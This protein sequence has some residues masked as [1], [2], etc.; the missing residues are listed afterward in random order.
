MNPS[1]RMLLTILL[2]LAGWS[3]ARAAESILSYQSDIE[4]A[5]DASMRV[6]ETITVRAEGDRIK[7]GIYRDFP[8]T[9]RDPLGQR[10]VTGFDIIGA[11]RDGQPEPWHSETLANGVRMYL[12]DGN[13]ILPPG[14][15][16]YQIEY[17]TTR[18]LGFFEDHDELYWNVTGNG[19]EFPIERASARVRLPQSVPVEQ[20]IASGYTGPTGSTQ[21]Q[22]VSTTVAGGADYRTTVPLD[23]E[24]GLSIVLQFPKGVVDEPDTQQKLLWL[25]ADNRQLLI[26]ALGLLLLWIYYVVMWRRHGRDPARGIVMP[27]YEPP[28]GY[29]PASLRYIRRMGYDQSCFAAA[30]IGLAAKGAISI[31]DNDGVITL[32]RSKDQPELAAGEAALLDKLLGSGRSIELKSSASTA[33]R[34]ASAR[35]AHEAALAADYEKKYFLTHRR[36]LI[37][38]VIFSIVCLLVAVIAMPGDAKYA[39]LFL[40]VFLSLWSIGTYAMVTAAFSAWRNARGFLAHLQAVPPTLISM[41]FLAGTVVGLVVLVSQAGYGLMAVFLAVI[42]TNIAFYHWMKEPTQDGAKLIDRIDGFR[43]YLGVAEKQELDAR[44]R[45]EDKPEQFSTFLPY[46]FALD[47]EQAWAR[48]FSDALPDDQL[49]KAQPDW[50]RTTGSTV[51]AVGCPIPVGL[52]FLQLIIGQGVRESPCPGLFDVEREGVG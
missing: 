49:K 3:G 9:Y 31:K 33:R 23:S 34:M 25:L 15:Y 22:L 1:Y 20:L 40:C 43:W 44:Y 17:R 50:Y 18:Q 16:T 14:E 30:I 47:V 26:G 39:V 4:I 52:C 48:R 11:T 27:L 24:E 41:P 46:A 8:T 5:A 38:A 12:G 51:G 19:W 13:V 36:K 42:G 37:P 29:S 7:R 10:Y 32:K 6:K 21:T 45:P 28:Q 35:K 2:A